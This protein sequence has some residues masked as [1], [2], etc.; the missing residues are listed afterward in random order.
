MTMLTVQELPKDTPIQRPWIAEMYAI[1]LGAAQ[2]GVHHRTY[3]NV[4]MHP[5]GAR[6]ALNKEGEYGRHTWK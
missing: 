5:P 4:V 1:A 6:S 3:H 2:L